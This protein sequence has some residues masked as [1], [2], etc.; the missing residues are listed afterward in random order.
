MMEVKNDKGRRE[1]RNQHHPNPLSSPLRI[2]IPLGENIYGCL[3]L[4]LL[5]TM[6]SRDEPS[7][8]IIR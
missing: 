3:P 5:V 6:K 8:Y 4:T 1:N 7:R 2:L